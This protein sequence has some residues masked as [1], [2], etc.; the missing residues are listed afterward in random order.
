[1]P[2]PERGSV[3]D[4]IGELPG[5]AREPKGGVPNEIGDLVSARERFVRVA[6]VIVPALE[7]T[8]AGP[9]ARVRAGGV[10]GPRR[11]DGAVDGAGQGQGANKDMT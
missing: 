4:V 8:Y 11:L 9:I 5:L 7:P 1:M 2:E 6:A 3:L 10:G